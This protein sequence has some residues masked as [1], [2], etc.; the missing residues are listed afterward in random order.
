MKRALST[1]FVM[2]SILACLLSGPSSASEIMEIPIYAPFVSGD[3]KAVAGTEK[4]G[5]RTIRWTEEEGITIVNDGS[6]DGEYFH[7]TGINCDGSVIVGYIEGSMHSV[8][9]YRWIESEGMMRIGFRNKL[10]P[11]LWFYASAYDVSSDGTVITGTGTSDSEFEYPTDS[12]FVLWYLSEDMDDLLNPASDGSEGQAISGDGRT[13]VG[14]TFYDINSDGYMDLSTE[15]FFFKWTESEG[16]KDI[17]LG[18]AS[19][20]SADGQVIIGTA[21]SG[22]AFRY[23][24]AGGMQEIGDFSPQKT[25]G[26]G[27]VIIGDGHVWDSINGL[28]SIED[29]LLSKGVDLD[30]DNWVIESVTDI[31]DDGKV[32][33]GKGYSIVGVVID[34]HDS[35]FI[36]GPSEWSWSSF[37]PGGYGG[38][39][40]YAP[41]GDG[42]KSAIWTFQ[43]T[44]QM[45]RYEILAQWTAGTNRAKDATY[46]IYD[47][48]GQIGSVKVD[49]T[50]N[51]GKFNSLGIFFSEFGNFKVIL[52]DNRSGYVIADAVKFVF[53]DKGWMAKLDEADIPTLSRIEIEGSS[54]V[55]ENDSAAYLCRAYYEDGTTEPVTAV[56]WSVDCSYADI[57]GSGLLTAY[58]VDGDMSCR[59]TAAYTADGITKTASKDISVMDDDSL[60]PVEIIIDNKNT[61]FASGPTAWTWSQFTPGGYNTSYQYAPIGSGSKWAK[62]TF[63]VS[64]PGEYEVFA[65]WTSGDNRSPAAPYTV[66]NG[67]NTWKVAANQTRNGGQFNL[68]GTY[69]LSAGTLEVLLNDTPTGVVIADAVKIVSEGTPPIKSLDRIEIEG[70]A[71][72]PENTSQNYICRAHYTDGTTEQVTADI[73]SDDCIDADIDG[74]GILTAYEVDGDMSCRI[75]AAYTA[76]GITKTAS[77]DISVMDD[78]SLEPVEIIIDN[79]NAGFASGPTAWTWSQFTPGGYNTSYQYAPIGSGSKWAKW[80][81]TVSAPGA[82][83]ILAQWTSGDN[84]SPAAPYTIKNGANTWTVTAN[85]TRDGGKFNLLGA[86][87]LT[88]GT[89]EVVLKDTP[90]GYVIADAVKIMT[91]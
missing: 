89:V 48:Y 14:N 30:S 60:E 80:T 91:P 79:K 75:T 21:P 83:Q 46:K 49:Q 74:T 23:T 7:P 44:G 65:Q 69:P 18:H 51:G 53:A 73:W 70:L 67:A 26:N 17:D 3:G 59:I 13:A 56:T 5:P 2:L 71:S 68:L 8:Y 20:I 22:Q 52:N 1:P 16:F 41:T 87:P 43:G 11:D 33:V 31:S 47:S 63:T 9:P 58:E 76:D 85:Q 4:Y 84:R 54:S 72:I 6:D 57:D 36:T 66:K 38:S 90:T 88:A 19:D 32:I 77:K 28:Q 86:Y 24:D 78:D 39:Y 34:N 10:W 82:Y 50:K 35:G 55:D 45:G 25:N 15:E 29:Y 40:Q 64:T 27:T 61:G 62:W 42:S 12:G 37:T 81:F